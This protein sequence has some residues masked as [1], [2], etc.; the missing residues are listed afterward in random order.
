MDE[1][2]VAQK[3]ADLFATW[4]ARA[5]ARGKEQRRKENPGAIDPGTLTRLVLGRRGNIPLLNVGREYKMSRASNGEVTIKFIDP[6]PFIDP[7]SNLSSSGLLVDMTEKAE[8]DAFAEIVAMG[9]PTPQ[10]V[11]ALLR[12][13]G[14][15][16][17]E[18]R[19]RIEAIARKACKPWGLEWSTLI[20]RYKDA[21]IAAVLRAEGMLVAEAQFVYNQVRMTWYAALGRA[22]LSWGQMAE[23]DQQ[24]WNKSGDIIV[25]ELAD[26]QNVGVESWGK[27]GEGVAQGDSGLSSNN[28]QVIALPNGNDGALE[29]TPR[30]FLKAMECKEGPKVGLTCAH[31]VSEGD[32]IREAGLVAYK[33]H[34]GALV[35]V[36]EASVLH[37]FRHVRGDRD[38]LSAAKDKLEAQRAKLK[39]E[40]ER[41]RGK[42]AERK[43]IF[44]DLGRLAYGAY[45]SEEMVSWDDLTEGTRMAWNHCASGV[46]AW[47]QKS[48]PIVHQR[49]SIG[50]VAAFFYLSGQGA[51]IVN[52]P[53]Y[54]SAETSSKRSSWKAVGIEVSAQAGSRGRLSLH[55]RAPSPD[56]PEGER[57]CKRCGTSF[58]MHLSDPK[59]VYCSQH[60]HK[61][62]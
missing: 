21:W 24:Q 19:K 10:V 43:S 44:I 26:K 3:Q 53:G 29:W 58:S 41:E 20:E 57:N 17:Q 1:A 15:R 42:R 50:E 51:A 38:R 37:A 6:G 40:L 33:N 34:D 54:W 45:R 32:R 62:S 46:V 39:A 60:C 4:Q 13:H 48:L 18:G 28:M 56:K 23:E 47:S 36:T 52:F 2:T 8:V 55:V 9:T 14:D 5:V 27:C 7:G 30:E 25:R 11:S 31:D 59:R 35:W 49:M 16:P 22:C 61:Y 12:R